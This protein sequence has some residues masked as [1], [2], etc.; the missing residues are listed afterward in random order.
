VLAILVPLVAVSPAYPPP[1]LPQTP[2]LVGFSFSPNE[3]PLGDDPAVDLASLLDQ[4]N[5]DLVRLPVYWDQVEPEPGVF[6]FSTVDRLLATVTH[7]NSSRHRRHTQ[8]L[9]VVGARNLGYPEVYVPAWV[10]AAFDGPLESVLQHDAYR[11]YLQMSFEHF[12]GSPLLYGWQAENEPLDNVDAGPTGRVDLSSDQVEAEIALLR[13]FDDVHPVVVTTYDSSH[14]DLDRMGASPLGAIVQRLPLLAK[15]VGHP[16]PTLGLGDVLG[17]DLY[18]VTPSTPLTD[19]GAIERIQWK[20][21]ALE[22][23]VRRAGS[24]GKQLWV[25][26]MQAAPWN[27]TNGFT[28]ADLVASAHIYRRGGASVVLLWGVEGWLTD[29]AW[30]TAGK[31]AVHILRAP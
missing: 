26:E 7:H 3:V 14:V 12:S 18:V 27:D 29:P 1:P 24:V 10:E 4:L 6:D 20:E 22:Y 19:A 31:Q 17:L 13:T 9:L 21:E 25:T 28:V 8:V 2:P 11:D 23:W 5:P 30:M 15:P 16:L